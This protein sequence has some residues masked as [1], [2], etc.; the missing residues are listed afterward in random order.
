[1]TTTRFSRAGEL[2]LGQRVRYPAGAP[3]AVVIGLIA[4]PLTTN[5]DMGLSR[6]DGDTVHTIPASLLVEVHA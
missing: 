3:W 1:M 5:I 2:R 6:S 4:V